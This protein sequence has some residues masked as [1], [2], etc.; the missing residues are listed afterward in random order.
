MIKSRLSLWF[1]VFAGL[2]VVTGIIG[3]LRGIDWDKLNGVPTTMHID[4]A[5]SSDMANNVSTLTFDGYNVKISGPDASVIIKDSSDEIIKGYTKHANVLYSPMVLF[6][7]ND[8]TD[9]SGGFVKI[10]TKNY[11]AYQ[12]DLRKILDGMMAGKEWSEIGVN[13]K[14]AKKEIAL[15]IP[16]ERSPYWDYIVELFYITMNDGK[17][18]TPEIR[19]ELK[20]TIDAILE[21]CE[22][23]YDIRE[24]IETEQK[25]P[26]SNR[27]VF[28]AP[29]FLYTTMNSEIMSY[30]N[31]N[32]YMPAYFHKTT[33][34]Y[35]DMYEKIDAENQINF[36]D[37]IRP[38]NAWFEHSGFRVKDTGAH[39]SN[40]KSGAIDF[41]P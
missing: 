7:R 29:E 12:I 8:V 28:I 5:Y 41:I 10:D 15:T 4:T 23:V 25:H 22:K 3:W 34:M 13:N 1:G 20:P 33:S 27:R 36:L 37:A 9:E 16:N 21:K 2:L 38:Y 19:E 26:S 11:Y 17:A 40:A 6:V 31:S 30:S 24:A 32:A 35:M 39:Y 14:V 18:L